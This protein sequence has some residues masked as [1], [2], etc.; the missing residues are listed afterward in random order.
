[1][2]PG[3]DLPTPDATDAFAA[4]LAALLGPGDAVLLSGPLGAGKS[5]FARAAIHARQ[6]AAGAPQD[7]VPSPTF[8]LVQTYQAGDLEIWHADLYRLGSADEI[9]ELGLDEAFETALVFVEW[10]ERLGSATPH[11]ALYIDLQTDTD[12]PDRRHLAWR[13][14][15]AG[16]DRVLP[17]L[18]Q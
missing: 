18:S 6:R 15:G 8:T 2:T 13:A 1:M 9:V 5:H 14:T 10:P 17:A 12:D 11:R 4:R 7:D 16:W 3:P